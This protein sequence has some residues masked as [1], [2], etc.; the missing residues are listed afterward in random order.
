MQA[1]IEI[2]HHQLIIATC[3]LAGR[4]MTEAG[5]E[6]Y[7]VE[8]T[9]NRIA[10]NAGSAEAF[11]Y[12]T[13]TGIFF[14]LSELEKSHLT[15][16]KERSINLEKVVSVNKLSRAFA[17][18]EIDLPLFYEELKVIDTA[19]PDF[20][21]SWKIIAAGVISCT[22]MW[23]IGGTWQD[24]IPAFLIGCFGFI[25]RILAQRFA[26][27]FLSDFLASLAIGVSASLLVH[28]QIANNIDSLIIGSVMP[29]VPGVAITNS[30]R[31]VLQGHLISGTARGIEALCT[32]GAIGAGIA[33][34]LKLFS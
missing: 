12:V 24:F 13:A 27:S 4:I 5:S 21:F 31:D 23:M 17:N 28:F 18:K 29:L 6:V 33:I 11:S 22:L 7:R 9:M 16:V 30:F 34:A 2:E 8:D 19:T 1:E 32:A 25:V 10:A 14:S 15:T 26:S 3:L 20:K